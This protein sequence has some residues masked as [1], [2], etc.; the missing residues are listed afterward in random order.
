MRS[1]K[2]RRR[3]TDVAFSIE[4]VESGQVLKVKMPDEDDADDDDGR[5][6]DEQH[7]HSRYDMY[8]S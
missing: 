8:V 4:H 5:V 7:I 6:D 1:R 2:G 3:I